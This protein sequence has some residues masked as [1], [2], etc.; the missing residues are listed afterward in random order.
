MHL[1]FLFFEAFWIRSWV[2]SLPCE[3][4][5]CFVSLEH[6]FISI[7]L[8]DNPILNFLL[9]WTRSLTFPLSIYFFPRGFT[10]IFL[11]WD[12]SLLRFFWFSESLS[13]FWQ[14]IKVL[15]I[16]FG[17]I[18]QHL[19]SYLYYVNLSVLHIFGF[20]IFYLF[21]FLNFQFSRFLKEK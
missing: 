11:M 8:V 16:L 10:I 14:V 9:F 21:P 12:F 20:G 2:P 17:I 18:F 13:S 4:S 19:W 6:N 5:G 7:E 3:V 1:W 15:T